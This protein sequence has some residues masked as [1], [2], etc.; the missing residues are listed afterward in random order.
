MNWE[1]IRAE[2]PSL[3]N[4]T[5]FNT[6]TYGQMPRRAVEAVA[7][8]FARRDQHA[9][10]DFLEWFDDADRIRASI[11]RLINAAPSDIA[12][13]PNAAT[14]LSLLINGI[15]WRPG[16]EVVTLEHEFP[17]YL[18]WAAAL[19]GRGVKPVSAPIG[20]VEIG[21]RTRLVMLSTA[22][23][24]TGRRPDLDRI[25]ADCRAAGALLCVDG[26]QSLGAIR[27]DCTAIQPDMF[28]MDG[29]KWLLSPNGAGFAYV[30]RSTRQWLQPS[31]IGWRSDRRWREV[32]ALHHGTPDFADAAEKYEGAQIPFPSI[33]GMGAVV[34][35]MLELGPAN[36]EARVMEL[37]ARTAA[38]LGLPAA[39]SH[40]LTARFPGHDAAELTRKLKE[41]RILTAA[42]HGHLRVSTHFYNNEE[43]IDRLRSALQA[44]L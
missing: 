21:P 11:A 43:D 13:F 38:V 36:I 19:Q 42:R 27:F 29:Y 24:V 23:Y 20:A 9:C 17:N 1:T 33:Y 34:D 4:W 26:T 3:E 15:D 30:P 12:F 18:Y 2:F 8:H 41:R 37:A 40:I 25:A 16:D 14:P 22:S 39:E 32:N 10:A 7:A 31:V 44:I 28:V 5:Y 6:A 35:W